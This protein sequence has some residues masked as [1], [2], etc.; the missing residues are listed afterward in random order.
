MRESDQLH[1]RI[2]LRVLTKQLDG[3][4]ALADL[5]KQRHAQLLSGACGG[6]LRSRLDCIGSKVSGADM[7]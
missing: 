6:E 5:R 2:K 7:L 3:L 1:Q 4:T